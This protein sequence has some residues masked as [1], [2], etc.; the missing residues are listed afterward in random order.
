MDVPRCAC[1]LVL[2][3]RRGNAEKRNRKQMGDTIS[4]NSKKFQETS[5]Q[6]GCWKVKTKQKQREAM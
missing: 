1:L 4:Q 2:R 3:E 6:P 5:E